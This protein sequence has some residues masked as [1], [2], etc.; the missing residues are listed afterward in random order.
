MQAMLNSKACDRTGIAACACGRHG[1][2][3][4]N[5]IADFFKGE[6]QKNIDWVLLQHII[7]TNI[8]PKQRVVSIYDIGCLYGM[9]LTWRLEGKLP[10]DM[11]VE[12]AIG[13]FHVHG[14][15][16][17][18]FWQFATTFLVH[19]GIIS[20]EI[21][22][23]LWAELNAI[24]PTARTATLAHRVELLDDHATDSNYRKMLGIGM[25]RSNHYVCLF[26]PDDLCA[27][28]TIG[29]LY[30][31]AQKMVPLSDMYFAKLTED[32]GNDN[33][34]KW[35]REIARAE[36]LRHID[37]SEMDIMA[38]R[39]ANPSDPPREESM[40]SKQKQPPPDWVSLGVEIEDRQ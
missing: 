19:C 11:A 9:Y 21:L 31:Q 33:V 30:R 40:T 22:E 36:S 7:C 32:A 2:F 20:G 38:S 29:R 3:A 39:A 6:Q 23:S 37:V 26:I 13:L 15:K 28:G 5:A 14:H 17:E 34:A 1:C 12:H 8:H 10:P 35:E 18:C 16:D 27:V 24:S 25:F 4:P